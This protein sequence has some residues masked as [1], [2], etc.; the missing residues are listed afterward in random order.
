MLSGRGRARREEMLAE[1]QEYMARVH[2]GR[3]RRR[4]AAALVM[5]L[6]AVAA[7]T[8]LL[9]RTP[10]PRPQPP[11]MRRTAQGAGPQEL[12]PRPEAPA[13]AQRSDASRI[14]RSDPGPP[15]VR[16][17]AGRSGLV[18]EIGD[19]ELLAWLRGLDRPTG[20]VRSGGH[21]WLT[22]SVTDAPPTSTGGG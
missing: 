9:L 10:G 1:L 20:L 18:R 6:G 2:R 17:W 12:S 8:P 19:E 22:A 15:S 7:A 5:S 13:I 16:L 14:A 3:A 11:D 4:Q 21:V